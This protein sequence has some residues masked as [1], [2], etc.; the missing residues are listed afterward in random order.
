M[1]AFSRPAL[2]RFLILYAALYAGFGAQSPYLPSLLESRDLRPE[3][4]ALVLAAGSA[5]RLVAGPAAGRLA[6]RLDAPK[7]ILSLCSAVAALIALG[8][9]PARGLW[10]LFAVG[11]FHSAA[12]APLAPLSDTLALGAA[13]AARSDDAV[14]R[15]F[16][17]G[18]VR[19]AGSAAFILG[20]VLSGQAV[21]HFGIA[22]VVWLNAALLAAAAFIGIFFFAIPFPLI[23]LAAA[24]IGFLGTASGAEVFKSD[25]G[26][27]KGAGKAEDKSL[28]GDELP[29]H[30]RPSVARALSVSAIWLALWLVPVF[31]VLLTLGPDNVFGQIAIF[32]SKMAVVTFGGAYAVLAYVAQEAVETYHWLKPGEMLGLTGLRGAGQETIGRAIFG[33]IPFTSGNCLLNGKEVTI[34][35]PAASIAMG[36]RFASGDRHAESVVQGFSVAE[37]LF[38]NPCVKDKSVLAPINPGLERQA[39]RALGRFIQL[40]PN[41]PAMLIENLSGGNQQKIVLGRWLDLKGKLLI[42]EDP[43]AGVDVGAKGEIYRLLFEALKTG[44]SIIVISTDFVEV[45]AI[46]TSRRETAEAVNTQRRRSLAL[47][48]LAIATEAIE[49]PGCLHASMA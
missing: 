45:A 49:P 33:L 28:L 37:N 30:A 9:L 42:L 29:E 38:L 16:E 47:M 10:L 3:A 27:G 48:P 46:C 23:I 39:A 8:Y 34:S 21:G 11:V 14:R 1:T 22:S 24:L 19:G 18:W 5:V 4:I 20:S 40:S 15:G 7:V 32:F 26:H 43:T 44:L 6:D 35:D 17:Y 36:L 31:A 13:A 25:G 12:L 2:S 41:D